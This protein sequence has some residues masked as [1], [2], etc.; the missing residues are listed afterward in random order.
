MLNVTI[1]R[2]KAKCMGF[3]PQPLLEPSLVLLRNDKGR[4]NEVLC[5][6]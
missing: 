6:G 1:T 2:T 5:G 4:R 3:L